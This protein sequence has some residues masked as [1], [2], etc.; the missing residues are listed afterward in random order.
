[1]RGKFI[2]LE[3]IDGSGKS[4]LAQKL[5]ERLDAKGVSAVWVRDPGSTPVSAAIRGLLLDPRNTDIKPMTELL[6]YCASRAQLLQ[7]VILPALERGENV[8][9]DRFYYSTFAYQGARAVM[10]EDRLHRLVLTA[11]GNIEPD[12][13]ILLDA[14]AAVCLGRIKREHDRMESLGGEYMEKVRGLYLRALE[15]LP[16][17]RKLILDAAQPPETSLAR[18]AAAVEALLR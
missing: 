10:P 7:E 4:T 9:S 13:A 5:R 17:N 8:V 3:G 14:P 18:A 11:A 16:E 1:M 6:L 12:L 2:V 15:K